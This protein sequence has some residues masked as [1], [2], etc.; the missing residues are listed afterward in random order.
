MANINAPTAMSG[1]EMGLLSTK[2]AMKAWGI[3]RN[4]IRLLVE[5]GTISPVVIGDRNWKFDP[6]DYYEIIEFHKQR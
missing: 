4:A 1:G 2:E 3:S 5:E 6:K